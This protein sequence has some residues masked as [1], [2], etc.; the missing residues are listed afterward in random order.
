MRGYNHT[1]D[2]ENL[3][4]SIEFAQYDSLQL[5]QYSNAN[6][7]LER[8]EDAVQSYMF[9]HRF[10][11]RS[12]SRKKTEGRTW[13]LYRMYARQLIEA[14]DDAPKFV[15]YSLPQP[16]GCIANNPINATAEQYEFSGPC[17]RNNLAYSTNPELNLPPSVLRQDLPD[18]RMNYAALAEGG[19]L[20]ITGL[21]SAKSY[22]SDT[23]HNGT[24]EVLLKM[25]IDGLNLLSDRI[26]PRKGT[27]DYVKYAIQMFREILLGI[28]DLAEIVKPYG[29]DCFISKSCPIMKEKKELNKIRKLVLGGHLASATMIQAKHMIQSPATPTLLFMPSYEV[30][31]HVLLLLDLNDDAKEMFEKALLE[32]MGRVQ[33]LVGLARSHAA[34]GN[35]KEA[36]YFYDY[37]KTQLD[38]ADENNPLL[39]E[40]NFGTKSK[41]D[42]A[43]LREQWRWPY[44]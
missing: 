20:L 39:E 1:Y 15:R 7:L 16:Y 33:S 36:N 17:S 13:E 35:D 29:F 30:Y 11:D 5:G 2:A 40:T 23:T 4:H 6:R 3:Y 24:E 19:A 9:D 41:I 14:Y 43:V 26:E 28:Q 31:G 25:C 44:L 22:S 37:L 32:R 18:G 38:E 42:L 34:L 21:S 10:K 27:M 8:M 12:I